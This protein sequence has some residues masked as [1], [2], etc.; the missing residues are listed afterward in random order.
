MAEPYESIAVTVVEVW[1][2]YEGTDYFFGY[3]FSTENNG[4]NSNLQVGTCRCQHQIRSHADPG[5]SERG[6]PK[7]IITSKPTIRI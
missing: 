4:D 2:G 6:K 1:W 7:A 5:Y 3:L